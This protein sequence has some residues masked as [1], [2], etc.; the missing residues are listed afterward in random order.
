[1]GNAAM[2]RK[3]KGDREIGKITY[4]MKMNK[5]VERS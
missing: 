3:R 5:S 4:H 2:E 1:M